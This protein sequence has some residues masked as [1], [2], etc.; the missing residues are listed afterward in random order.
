MIIVTF[1]QFFFIQKLTSIFQ[2]DVGKFYIL[3]TKLTSV[4][5]KTLVSFAGSVLNNAL[6]S[7]L[8]TKKFEQK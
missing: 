7:F 5:F 2:Q 8:I 6:V 3:Y 1:V 4:L